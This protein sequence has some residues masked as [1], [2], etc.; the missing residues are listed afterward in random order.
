MKKNNFQSLVIN[1]K[2]I[3][4]VDPVDYGELPQ[5]VNTLISYCTPCF[6]NIRPVCRT[7]IT[8]V[9]DNIRKCPV[10]VVYLVCNSP[11][12]VTPKCITVADV[13]ITNN[14]TF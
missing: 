12:M 3:G 14:L 5:E 8:G 4:F 2:T 7:T 13:N 1:K 9:S 10:S 11:S 6:S